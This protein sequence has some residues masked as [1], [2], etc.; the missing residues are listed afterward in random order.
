MRRHYLHLL[1]Y[2]GVATAALVLLLP[3]GWLAV[4][5]GGAIG[6]GLFMA[7]L[8]VGLAAALVSI[9]FSLLFGAPYVPVSPERLQAM[10]VLSRL[11]AGESLVDL[12]S[13]DGCIL[14]EAARRGASAAGWEI[15][16]YLCAWTWLAARWCGVARRVTVHCSSYWDDTY[17]FADVVALYL[18]PSQMARLEKKLLKELHPGARVVSAGFTFPHWLPTEERDGVRLYVVP[19]R[20]T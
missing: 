18:L 20:Q 10:M 19:P 7:V 6:L 1:A 3:L 2:A 17:G 5:L 8:C 16:P 14:I 9:I 11:K 15:N 13:G 4:W 12:G